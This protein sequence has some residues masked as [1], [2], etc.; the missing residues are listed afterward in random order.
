[1]HNRLNRLNRFQKNLAIVLLGVAS[2]AFLSCAEL[3][4]QQ[5]WVLMNQAITKGDVQ[6][7]RKLGNSGLVDMND[8]S[9]IKGRFLFKALRIANPRISIPGV[10]EALFQAGTRIHQAGRISQLPNHPNVTTNIFYYASDHPGSS[11]CPDPSA[12]TNCPTIEVLDVLLAQFKIEAQHP[13]GSDDGGSLA[14]WLSE[15]NYPDANTLMAAYGDTRWDIG[16]VLLQNGVRPNETDG[17]GLTAI[18]RAAS[19]KCLKCIE[20]AAKYSANVNARDRNGKSILFSMAESG[21]NNGNDRPFF[22]ALTAI[23]DV[24]IADNDGLT[25]YDWTHTG[26]VPA[27]PTFHCRPNPSPSPNQVWCQ[28]ILLAAGA[29]ARQ[30]PPT[31]PCH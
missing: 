2:Y 24:N 17:N 30:L 23:V 31:F 9:D 8:T 14:D 21:A 22:K 18:W 5:P 28:Q 29:S 12:P 16:D 7:I 11:P 10:L 27:N 6:E 13:V 26:T 1:M 20:N 3:S 4:A 19:S 15:M 25:A